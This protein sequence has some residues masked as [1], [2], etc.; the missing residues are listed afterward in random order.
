MAEDVIC[1]QHGVGFKLT[2]PVAVAMLQAEHPIAGAR[3]GS[4]HLPERGIQA[5]KFQTFRV[6]GFF[7][8]R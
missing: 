3:N 7:L 8:W 1:L 6:S 2:A 5:S 4:L